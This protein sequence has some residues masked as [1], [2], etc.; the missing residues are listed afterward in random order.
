MG[1][2]SSRSSLWM[3]LSQGDPRTGQTAG[4]KVVLTGMPKVSEMGQGKQAE[5]LPR[6]NGVVGLKHIPAE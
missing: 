6:K 3:E 2:V 1:T 5:V 4:E